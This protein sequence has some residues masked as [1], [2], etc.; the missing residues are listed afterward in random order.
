MSRYKY[1][2]KDF[3]AIKDAQIILDGITVLSGINGCGKST[4]S[5]WLYY[6]VEGT[7]DYDKI[8]I[9]N[10]KSNLIR[11][12]ERIHFAFRDIDRFY[13]QNNISD[14]TSISL[15]LRNIL[16]QLSSLDSKSLNNAE[17]AHD[18]FLQIIFSIGNFFENDKLVDLPKARAERFFSFL[19]IDFSVHTTNQAIDTFINVHTRWLEDLTRK[20]NSALNDRP[21][22]LFF[23][24]ISS[25]Y[26]VDDFPKYFQLE[27]DGVDVIEEQIS[28]IYNL[29][30]VIYIDTPMSVTIEESDN[31]FWEKLHEMMMENKKNNSIEDRK[32]LLRIK[33][34]LDGET[35]L[36]DDD[37]FLENKTLRY[38]SS[39][40]KINIDLKEAATGF[41]TFSYL[42][43][44]LE[45]GYLNKHTL[46]M[47]DEPEAHLHPQWIVDYARLIVLLN[48]HLGLKVMLASHN[49]DMVA[50]IQ[51]I[52]NKEGILDNTNF[53]VANPSAENPHQFVYK[54]LGHEIGEIFESFNIALDRIESYGNV[55]LK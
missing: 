12:L 49:P 30:Q 9:D 31:F 45:N 53:Y 6:V 4:L 20:L 44:L 1:I 50:A 54:Y 19:G 22:D 46:L 36:I 32:I 15:K 11:L 33:Y 43:R 48:K 47:I 51:A 26:H 55:D 35:I 8:L 42:Q 37:D 38:I 25:K 2:I 7:V 40:K 18:L 16:N 21:S 13:R 3:H 24:H 17:I 23:Q 10:Y 34:L 28:N 5:R 39:D 14:D 41:K 52:A 29:N 27:E